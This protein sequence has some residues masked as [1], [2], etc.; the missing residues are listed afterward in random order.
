MSNPDIRPERSYVET[1]ERNY[2]LPAAVII[3]VILAGAAAAYYFTRPM[4]E[5]ALSTAAYLRLSSAGKDYALRLNT[6]PCNRNI[7]GRLANLLAKNDE[8]AATIK[9]VK[10][11]EAKCGDNELLWVPMV[12]AQ[13][14]GS[15]YADAEATLDRAIELHPNAQN[16]YFQRAKARDAQGNLDGAY[17]DYRKAIYIY[18]DPADLNSLTFEGMSDVAVKL[19]RPCEAISIMQDYIAFDNLQRRAPA[20]LG[21]M[22]DWQKQGSCPNPFGSGTARLKYEHRAGA[23]ILPV[24]VNGVTGRMIVDTGASRTALTKKFAKRAGVEP[25]HSDGALVSTANGDVWVMGGRAEEISLGKAR[26]QNIPI[27]VQ[28]DGKGFGR[29][30]DGLLGLSFLGNFKV[31]LNQGQLVLEPI[32]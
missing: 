3:C 29:D 13:M 20:F 7:A 19:G 4:P 14:G 8:Y 11:T 5:Y 26:A 15:R 17:D 24:T 30:I 16:A 10:A 32:S 21:L 18:S 23:I 27:F 25:S 9:F 31:T 12:A 1:T 2:F 22:R 28:E 6:E